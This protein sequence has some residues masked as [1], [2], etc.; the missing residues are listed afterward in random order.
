LDAGFTV[1]KLGIKVQGLSLEAVSREANQLALF[2]R[3]RSGNGEI[4]LEGS[5]T[6]SPRDDWP[7]TLTLKGARFLAAD[8]PEARVYVS[9]DLLIEHKAPGL[10]LTGKL[11]IPEAA[12]RIPDEKGAVKPSKDVVI[13]GAEAPPEAPGM[14]LEARID[15][16]LGDKG[17]HSGAGLSGAPGWA[18]DDRTIAV[19][20]AH[21][22]RPDQH[23]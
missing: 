9:P 7:M 14:P 15:V 18:G 6:L 16:V 5:A 1:P 2:G 19:P 8:I 22:H 10:S 21:R 17:R 20:A 11:T 4:R 13:A 23:P 12:I 3:A